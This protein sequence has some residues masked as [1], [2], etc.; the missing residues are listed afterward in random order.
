MTTAPVQ[1]PEAYKT[2]HETL[3]RW[4]KRLRQQQS[5][6]WL[7][8]VLL[9]ALA[10]GVV[11]GTLSRIR[12]WLT[13]DQL[14]LVSMLAMAGG[15]AALVGVVWLWPRKPI[16]SARWFD[17]R[18]GLQE[19]LST[20]LELLDGEIHTVDELARRQLAD[21]Q[22]HAVSVDIH[23]RLPLKVRIYEWVGVFILLFVLTAL[24]FLPNTTASAK[25]TNT[26]LRQ[27]VVQTA[28][29]VRDTLEEV[30][31]DP[32]L[33]AEAREEL[34][35]ALE[36]S[37]ETLR[38]EDISAE[39]ALAT[40]H[41]VETMLQDQSDALKELTEAERAEIEEA[42]RGLERPDSPASERPAE[43]LESLMEEVP[44]QTLAE[45][46]G[47]AESLDQL[48]DA[49]ENV[50]PGA[51]EALREAAE[52]LRNGDTQAA[53]DALRRAMEELGTTESEMQ[54]RE[55][56]AERMEQL[57]EQMQQNQQ[58]IAEQGST[59]QQ[60]EGMPGESETQAGEGPPEPGPEGATGDEG[61]GNTQ[62][63]SNQP[64][65]S[66]QQGN[67]QDTGNPSEREGDSGDTGSRSDNL[68][69]DTTGA[70]A[71]AEQAPN[72]SAPGGERQY[73][74][75]Y[76]PNRPELEQGDDTIQLSAPEGDIPL[77][78]IDQAENPSGTVTVP[79]NQV[80]SNYANAATA[81]LDQSYIPLGLRDV[82]RE[83]FMS[84]APA[85]SQYDGGD[86]D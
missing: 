30:A 71:D 73:E 82:V 42:M 67:A 69:G 65:D 52:A 62:S 26:A 32:N 10:V 6:A 43:R 46:M 56:S 37:L 60:N 85:A 28:D 15:V 74:E 38:E 66:A 54:S 16:A 23:K 33:D 59:P 12:P 8:R 48:A 13:N 9:A 61:G 81:A 19:R 7:A 5:V 77:R 75:I 40:A 47:T 17:L 36:A 35:K 34:L 79:Y 58:D 83:Y 41:D 84:L 25:T 29:D 21:A 11:V 22:A 68:R 80:F 14:A 45:M 24:V 86:G 51:A 72:M 18:L 76:A 31:A 78:E 55:Q 64:S 70:S 39:E 1:D 63:D 44:G 20:A 57:A 50:A 53:Q 49:L 4:E 3:R 2:L 27:A